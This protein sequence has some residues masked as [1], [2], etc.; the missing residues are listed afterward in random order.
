MARAPRAAMAQAALAGAAFPLA[1]APFGWWPLAVLAPAVLFRLLAAPLAPRRAFALGWA[2]G[3]GAFGVG[4]SWVYVSLHDYGGAP[5]PLA[6]FLTLVFVAGLALLPGLLGWGVARLAPPGA[7]RALLSLPA[8]WALLEWVR[9][10]L[11]TGFPWLLLA[12]AMTDAPLAGLAPVLGQHGVGLAAAWLAGLLAWAA[13]APRRRAAAAAAGLALVLGAGALAARIEWTRPAGEPV[14]VA[15]VQGNVSQR[16]KW[17]PAERARTLALYRE[18]TLAEAGRAR[19]V[20]WPESAIPAFADQARGYLDDLA[21]RL[22]PAGTALVTGILHRD[23]RTGVYHNSILAVGSGGLYHKRHL[24]PFGEVLPLR[25]LLGRAANLLN[26]PYA[27]FTPGPPMQ[28]P[29]HAGGLRLGATVCYEI[30][31]PALVRS[32]LPEAGVLVNVSNDGWFGGSLAPHQHLQ[33]ARLRALETGRP[34]LRA[35]NTGIT[36]VID[37]R[38]RLRARAPQFEV[39]VARARVAPRAG[40]TPYVRWGDAPALALAGAALA[41]GALALRGLGPRGPGAPVP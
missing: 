1:F 20:V 13:G 24:V 11:L 2:F 7:A 39:A 36:A 12:H 41:L 38:G 22:A 9:G 6:A 26:V 31:F 18:L 27:D 15:L 8:A 25:G 14:A 16:R 17:L 33:I 23:R 29:L 21:A 40:A 34:L 37:A 19:L 10:W 28:P 3:L 5:A 30:A 35:T 4:V 32:A